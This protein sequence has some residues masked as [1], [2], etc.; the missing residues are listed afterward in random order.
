M[1]KNK[2]VITALIVTPILAVLGYFSMDYIVSERP[3]QAVAGGNYQL[4][5]L[6]NC[7]Y[8]SGKCELKN[9]NFKVVVTGETEIDGGL[10]LHLESVFPLD[11]AHV[12]VVNTPSEIIEPVAMEL[13]SDDGTTTLKNGN[14]KVVVTGE[15]EI[16]GGLRL[17]LESVFPLDTAHVSVVNTPSEIIEPV[18][19]ELSSDDG[20]TWHVDM[21]VSNPQEQFLRVA[22]SAN[23]AIY[24]AETKMPFLQYETSFHKDFRKNK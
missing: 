19:M 1:F 13:S 20:T 2:H 15:T 21:M 16:D 10:R 6:P 18:A 11:T 24:Y 14:F 4:V 12:S 5:Q 9:G 17:H 22:V 8:A 7:R 23:E 3:H